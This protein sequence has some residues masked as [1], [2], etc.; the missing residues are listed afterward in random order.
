M[1]RYIY[2]WLNTF[3]LCNVESFMKLTIYTKISKFNT[4]FIGLSTLYSNVYNIVYPVV[5]HL[6]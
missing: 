3:V 2:S 5:I 6:M 4:Q 1:S